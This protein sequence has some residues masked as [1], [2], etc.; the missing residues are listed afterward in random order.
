[1]L[2]DRSVRQF[3]IVCLLILMVGCK[4]LSVEESAFREAAEQICRELGGEPTWAETQ[5]RAGCDFYERPQGV[6]TDAQ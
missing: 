3:V 2:S 4:E 5:H 1:M 6:T